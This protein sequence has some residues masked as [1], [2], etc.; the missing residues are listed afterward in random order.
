VEFIIGMGQEL[1][2][3]L[4]GANEMEGDLRSV[5][6]RLKQIQQQMPRILLRSSR[7]RSSKW[8]R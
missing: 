4:H 2:A 6:G 7:I 8:P 1:V 5:R 3:G